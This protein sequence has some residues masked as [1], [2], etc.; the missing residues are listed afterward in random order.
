MLNMFL[1]TQK[2]I[3]LLIIV[4][5]IQAVQFLFRKEAQSKIKK[6][7]YISCDISDKGSLQ[8]RILKLKILN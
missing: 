2:E 5:I 4:Q 8:R 3:L 7:T 6:L 1:L